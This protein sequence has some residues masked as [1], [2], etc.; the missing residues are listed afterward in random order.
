MGKNGAFLLDEQKYLTLASQGWT[1]QVSL[2]LMPLSLFTRLL[3][4]LDRSY[5]LNVPLNLSME[6]GLLVVFF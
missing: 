5:N 2:L 4:L 3:T 1:P 6:F